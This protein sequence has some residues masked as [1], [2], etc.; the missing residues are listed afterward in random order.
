[1]FPSHIAC[2]R[3]RGLLERTKGS[4][5]IPKCDDKIVDNLRLFLENMKKKEPVVPVLI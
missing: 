5:F 2:Q 1:M 3:P 4:N